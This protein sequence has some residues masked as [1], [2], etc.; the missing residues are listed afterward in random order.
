MVRRWLK[1][2][3]SSHPVPALRH[4]SKCHEMPR[5]R[6]P[7]FASGVVAVAVTVAAAPV[8]QS[9][10]RH[11]GIDLTPLA[12]A[13]AAHRRGHA[14]HRPRSPDRTRVPRQLEQAAR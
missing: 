6:F 2:T 13:D 7:V 10:L 14:S 4:H 9:Q 8:A 5:V 11:I 1:S 12:E 3:V